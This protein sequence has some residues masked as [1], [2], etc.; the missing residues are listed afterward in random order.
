MLAS[1]SV[2][3]VAVLLILCAA[4]E[5]PNSSVSA[6]RAGESLAMGLNVSMVFRATAAPHSI[7]TYSSIATDLPIAGVSQFDRRFVS[8]KKNSVSLAC[9]ETKITYSQKLTFF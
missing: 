4:T 7:S 9:V 2:N 5:Y 1:V 8:Q 6:P 3:P